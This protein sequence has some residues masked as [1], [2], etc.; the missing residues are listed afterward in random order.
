MLGWTLGA[1]FSV[2]PIRTKHDPI[3]VGLTIA[4]VGGFLLKFGVNYAVK[5][6]IGELF[7]WSPEV[8]FIARFMTTFVSVIAFTNTEGDKVGLSS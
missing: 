2:P 1:I 6:A 7:S 4:T 3:L 8:S 5:D